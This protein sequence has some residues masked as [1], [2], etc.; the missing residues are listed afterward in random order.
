MVCDASEKR[1]VEAQIGRKTKVP[2]T[3]VKRC[4]YGYPMVIECFPTDGKVPFPTLHW[5]TCPYL[6]KEIARLEEKG[7]IKQLENLLRIS[8]SFKR[9]YEKAVEYDRKRKLELLEDSKMDSSWVYGMGIGG[10]RDLQHIKCLHLHVASYLAGIPNPVGKKVLESL[11][12]LECS[13]PLCSH[14]I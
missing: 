5:L 12:D 10:I 2:F 7:M 4:S 1:V 9:A 13:V 6:R 11:D 8:E 14:L 3:V